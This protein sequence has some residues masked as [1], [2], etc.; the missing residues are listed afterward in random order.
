MVVIIA[1][2]IVSTV[3]SVT[4]SAILWMKCGQAA[5]PVS[6]LTFA[7]AKARVTQSSAN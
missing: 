4:V 1:T 2:A 7:R 6:P 5:L 3:V